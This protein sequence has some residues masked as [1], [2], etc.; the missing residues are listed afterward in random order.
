MNH[1]RHTSQLVVQVGD[2]DPEP[3]V[4]V[5]P[6]IK[7]ELQAIRNMS[8]SVPEYRA[9]ADRY[10]DAVQALQIA[11]ENERL[12]GIRSAF[13]TLHEI[14]AQTAFLNEGLC[15]AIESVQKQKNTANDNH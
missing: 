4:R 6:A 3:V 8:F 5:S 9:L 11:V 10:L 12:A 14:A 7:A 13:L 15:H 1:H 2:H